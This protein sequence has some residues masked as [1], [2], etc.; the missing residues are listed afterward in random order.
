MS[1]KKQSVLIVDDQRLNIRILSSVL[2]EEYHVM[3][4]TDGDQA[5]AIARSESP[6][7]LILLDITMPGMDGYTVC[8][9]LKESDETRHIPVIFATAKDDIEDETKGFAM[10]AVDYIPKPFKLPVVL[11]RV[12]THLRIQRHST[13]LEQM[14]T[15]DGLTEIPNRRRFDDQLVDEWKRGIRS[16]HP[17]SLILL[18]VDHFKL[19]NDHYGHSL[20]DHCLCRVAKALEGAIHRTSDLVARYGGEEFVAVL[21]NTD[22]AGA[23]IVAESMRRS[24]EELAIPHA[25]SETA[26]EVTVS[27]GGC[28]LIP[29]RDGAEPE[30][31][32]RAADRNLYAAKG[33]GRNRAIVESCALGTP[34]PTATQ[35]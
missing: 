27:A 1:S 30:D 20:G 33:A 7:D 4:A 28:T 23:R 13:M 22:L 24:V 29:P 8:R 21:P 5:L 35:D 17:L 18:D 11:A 9:T 34:K 6:P 32:I 2:E 15:I 16:R 10:G 12:R 19:F 3:S 25:P 14:A 31:L 26:D